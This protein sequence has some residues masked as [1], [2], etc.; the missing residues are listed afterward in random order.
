VEQANIALITK[1]EEELHQAL[2][3]R[4]LR[5]VDLVGLRVEDARHLRNEIYA[6]HGR[7][8]KDPKLQA[9]FVSFAWYKP[10][11]GFREG[12]LSDVERKNA[13]II[14]AYENQQFTEG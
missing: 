5:E 6:R 13:E 9:Y 2:A 7:R 4:M 12:V 11:D 8:F 1:R 14:R 10:Y 3:T